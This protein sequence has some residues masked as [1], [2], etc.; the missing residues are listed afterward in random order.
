MSKRSTFAF[1]RYREPGMVRTG[2]TGQTEWTYERR[3][4]RWS[5]RARDSAV[6]RI[7][8]KNERHSVPEK[9]KGE[10]DLL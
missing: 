10:M 4:E 7:G 8:Y 5:R 2:A 9:A 1:R 3:A 6:T